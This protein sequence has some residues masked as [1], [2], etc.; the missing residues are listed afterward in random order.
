MNEFSHLKN[1]L[2]A[3]WASSWHGFS[4]SLLDRRFD[5]LSSCRSLFSS[6]IYFLTQQPLRLMLCPERLLFFILN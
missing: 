1:K 4:L 6:F 3:A 2:L 5:S